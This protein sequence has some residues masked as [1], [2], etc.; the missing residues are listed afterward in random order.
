MKRI[1]QSRRP[2]VSGVSRMDDA[3][4]C[5]CARAGDATAYQLVQ[6]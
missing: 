3:L 6:D 2:L 4:L 5:M 1:Q